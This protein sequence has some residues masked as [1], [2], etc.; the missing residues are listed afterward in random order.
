MP[1]VNVIKEYKNNSM[2][3]IYNRGLNKQ[4]CF[5]SQSDYLFMRNIIKYTLR[6]LARKSIIIEVSVFALMP[7]HFHFIVYQQNSRSITK[8]MKK[9][10]I[11][12]VQYFNKKY[13]R[14]GNLF[15]RPYRARL[16]RSTRDVMETSKYVLQNPIEAHLP[17]DWDHVGFDL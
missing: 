17:R 1:S 7:N 5:L 6:E 10:T 13:E 2:Y 8:F 14:T 11:H 4:V 3:H 16:L 15:A 9:I 12:Y